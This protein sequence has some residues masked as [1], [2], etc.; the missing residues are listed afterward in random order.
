MGAEAD[1]DPRPPEE[2]DLSNIEEWSDAELEAW[3]QHTR[4]SL[5]DR[6]EE[7]VGD[8]SDAVATLREAA[9][10]S[11]DTE[12]VTLGDGVEL[13]VRTRIPPA[14]EDLH[15]KMRQ[16]DKSGNLEVARR[17]NSQMLAEMVVEPDKFA[18]P[19]VWATASRDG[20][21]GMQWLAEATEAITGPATER[22]EELEGN[23]THSDGSQSPGGGNPSGWQRQR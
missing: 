3:E 1:N 19:D 8:E 18:D 16:A 5:D 20:D 4:E 7:S 11:L 12:T 10:D 15:D 2:L 21:A 22:A 17:L 9:T 6:I 14:V 13:E 23:A